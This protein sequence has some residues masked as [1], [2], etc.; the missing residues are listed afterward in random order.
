MLEKWTGL[1]QDNKVKL[2]I[3]VLGAVFGV[4][5]SGLSCEFKAKP[6]PSHRRVWH[7]KAHYSRKAITGSQ[8]LSDLAEIAKYKQIPATPWV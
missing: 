7:R 8:K 5:S 4:R 1:T 3:V 2:I 6:K